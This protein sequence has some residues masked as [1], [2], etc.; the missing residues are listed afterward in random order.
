MATGVPAGSA[1]DKALK[2]NKGLEELWNTVS[3]RL[4]IVEKQTAQNTANDRVP[5]SAGTTPPASNPITAATGL[6]TTTLLLIVGAA[7]LLFW[8]WRK[9]K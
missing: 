7:V 4:G 3:D 9:K 6:D 8:F 5:N 1:L 2:K